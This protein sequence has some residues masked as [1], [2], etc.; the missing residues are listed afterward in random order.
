M[1]NGLSSANQS[2]TGEKIQ[3]LPEVRQAGRRQGALQDVSQGT[4]QELSAQRK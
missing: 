1:I 3:A 4:G 2:Q